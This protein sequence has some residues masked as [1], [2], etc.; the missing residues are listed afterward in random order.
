[1]ATLGSVHIFQAGYETLRQNKAAEEVTKYI[2]KGHHAFLGPFHKHRAGENKGAHVQ[3][4]YVSLTIWF[5]SCADLERIVLSIVLSIVPTASNTKEDSLANLSIVL[6]TRGYQVRF[7]IRTC[8]QVVS[9]IP[10]LGLCMR[11]L[12]NVSL[13]IDCY[14]SLKSI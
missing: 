11:H 12:F 14:L 10:I 2:S 13:S 5:R 3:V 4:A 8:T 6:Y 7:L 1:M 9:W